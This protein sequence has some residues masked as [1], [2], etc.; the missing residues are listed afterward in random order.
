MTAQ[1]QVSR[2]VGG[3]ERAVIKMGEL[4]QSQLEAALAALDR[5][6]PSL[7][8]EV[9]RGDDELDRWDVRV[10]TDALKTLHR[11]QLLEDEFRL[12]VAIVKIDTQLERIGDLAVNI[13][14]RALSL[15][16]QPPLPPVL[17]L[18]LIADRVPRMVKASMEA[19][20][21][22]DPGHAREVLGMDLLVDELH[23]R[24]YE[25]YEDLMRKDPAT[26]DR[27][28]QMLSCSRH[29]ERIGDHA[30]NIAEDVIYMVEGEI[31]RHSAAVRSWPPEAASACASEVEGGEQ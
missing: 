30:K 3:L 7:A 10:E 2:A 6:D 19:F 28:V 17:E 29:L 8:E 15:S 31:V 1:Q 24:L 26:I 13:A 16:A 25:V 5:R 23:A 9:I 12:V 11:H 14:E 22:G 20:L 4:V 27:A 18:R 21:D